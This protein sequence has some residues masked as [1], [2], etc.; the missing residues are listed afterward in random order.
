MHALI[1]AGDSS[2]AKVSSGKVPETK[3]AKSHAPAV[4]KEA[5][6]FFRR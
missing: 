3:K 4:Q 6:S 2:K 5:A 1:V